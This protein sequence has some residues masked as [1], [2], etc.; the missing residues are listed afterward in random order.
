MN[1]TSDSY[2]GSGG[3]TCDSCNGNESCD[4]QSCS[5]DSHDYTACHNNNVYWFDACGNAES[6][7]ENCTHG[8]ASGEC[9]AYAEDQTNLPL[10]CETNGAIHQNILTATQISVSDPTGDPQITVT[11]EKC[12]GSDFGS[13]KNCHV[14]VGAPGGVERMDFT[15]YAGTDSY[16]TTF[17]GWPVGS[18]F[19]DAP[20]GEDKEFYVTCDDGYHYAYWISD[21]P[22]RIERVCD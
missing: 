2:C 7:D 13:T 4:Y 14:H 10:D 8:C 16:T 21:D 11:W 19:V 18:P 5:C 20:C 9:L 15:W 3:D 22:V 6:I 1:G 17:E 12:D